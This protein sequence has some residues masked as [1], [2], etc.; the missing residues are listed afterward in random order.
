MWCVVRIVAFPRLRPTNLLFLFPACPFHNCHSRLECFGNTYGSPMSL[1]DMAHAALSSAGQLICAWSEGSRKFQIY[2]RPDVLGRIATE[3]WV[4]F[5]RV[6]HRGLEI[7]GILLGEVYPQNDTTTF[8]IEGFVEVASEH[9]LGPSYL[10]SDSDFEHLQEAIVKHGAASIGVFRSQTRSQ[11]LALA[12]SDLELS[13][14]CFGSGDALFLMACPVQGCG[15]FFAR[16]EGDLKQIHEFPLVSSLASI[17][18][19]QQS[20]KPVQNEALPEPV[21]VEAPR[22]RAAKRSL[23]SQNGLGPKSNA[24]RFGNRWFE[25]ARYYRAQARAWRRQVFVNKGS[26]WVLA[27]VFLLALVA[28]IGGGHFY[29][30]RRLASPSGPTPEY[31]SLRVERVGSSL[32]IL[33]DRDAS[34]IRAATH[35]VLHIQDGGYLSDKILSRPE[36]SAGSI[37]Y[38]PKGPDLSF[39]LEMYS[40]APAA[41]GSVEVVSLPPQGTIGPSRAVE[42]EFKSNGKQIPNLP[43][44]APATVAGIETFV[45]S[46][47]AQGAKEHLDSPGLRSNDVAVEETRLSALIPSE[48]SGTDVRTTLPASVEKS[49]TAL[50]ATGNR[51]VPISDTATTVHVTT[52]LVRG[53]RLGRLVGRIPLLRRLNKKEK[54]TEPVPVLHPEPGVNHVSLSK[55]V[56]VAIKVNIGQSGG[57]DSAEVVE[58]GEP[59]NFMLANAALASARQWT[60]HPA[61][62]QDTPVSS[63]VVLHYLFS[64]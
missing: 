59:P 43:R 4:A 27:G 31:L 15:A 9:R 61:L 13:E 44:A 33:W 6:P 52:E 8:L 51:G 7:G 1:T 42:R 25:T 19:I 11:Q 49:A 3:S 53:W 58:Y 32:R 22:E 47:A 24:H 18:T 62:L 17:L 46:V 35:A 12:N 21:E 60:F 34:S 56:S 37:M 36:L 40:G 14:R 45:H 2:V 23:H 29:S 30:T 57:V 63:E 38:G 5:K 10:L 50:T 39:R 48:P 55:P 41:I 64:P 16:A 26:T 20:R 28:V 54:L